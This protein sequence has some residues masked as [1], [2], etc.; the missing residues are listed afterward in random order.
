MRLGSFRGLGE[1]DIEALRVD[2]AAPRV[3]DAH[4]GSPRIDATDSLGSFQE[5]VV[6][7]VRER[8]VG[9]AALERK[10]D[11]SHALVADGGLHD[12]PVRRAPS[13]ATD[14]GQCE[15][16]AD[17]IVVALDHLLRALIP[18][19][20]LVG[21][22]P[23]DQIAA[24]SEPFV[25]ETPDGEGHRCRLVQHVDRAAPPHLAVDELA[26][27]RI[28]RPTVGLVRRDD[29]GVPHERQRRRGRVRSG[30]AR[31]ERSATVDGL[32][33]VDVDAGSFHDGTQGVGVDRFVAQRRDAV[34]PAHAAVADQHPEQFGHLIAQCSI[35]RHNCPRP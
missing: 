9:L 27:E 16:G 5:R 4:L 22:G 8:R 24:R 26:P 6:G 3:R 30:D 34:E 13:R 33:P 12:Q 35:T 21:H 20:L 7:A 11:T 14:L 23:E 18:A 25:G 32:V 15:V 2:P 10:V 31:H 1:I 17:Q 28:S 29:V 19:V